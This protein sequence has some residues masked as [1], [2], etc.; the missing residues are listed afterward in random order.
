MK[1]S[2]LFLSLLFC[3]NF[4]LKAQL[5]N[6]VLIKDFNAEYLQI[7]ERELLFRGTK[8]NL[9]INY[10]QPTK[11]DGN[12]EKLLRDSTGKKMEFN[13]LID[14]LNFMNENGYELAHPY[15]PIKDSFLMRRKKTDPANELEIIQ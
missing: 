11:M 9:L 8:I 1:T 13:S 15:G 14:A 5:V 4:S 10:G 3:I 2:I 12:V 6:G 7:T